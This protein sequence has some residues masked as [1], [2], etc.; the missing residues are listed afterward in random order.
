MQIRE[1][2]TQSPLTLATFG[3]IFSEFLP[4]INPDFL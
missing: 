2:D 1:Y 3:S 4:D